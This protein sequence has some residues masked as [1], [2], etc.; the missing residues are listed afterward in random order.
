MRIKESGAYLWVHL[1]K[2]S[3][4]SWKV[5]EIWKGTRAPPGRRRRSRRCPS[6]VFERLFCPGGS[7]SPWFTASVSPLVPL[8]PSWSVVIAASET[9][10]STKTR[11]R[12]GSVLMDQRWLQ[13]INKLLRWQC[14]KSGKRIWYFDNFAA[15]NKFKASTDVWNVAA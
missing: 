4:R 7:G 8:L 3:N 14:V 10:V 2:P 6:S 11:A 1:V 13:W 5:S 9:G 12:D 15:A